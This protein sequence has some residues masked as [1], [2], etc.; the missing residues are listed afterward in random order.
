MP[1]LIQLRRAVLLALAAVTGVL[2][3]K[4]I[5]TFVDFRPAAITLGPGTTIYFSENP[6]LVTRV[7]EAIHRR[8]MRNKSILGRLVSAVRYNFD[9]GYRLEEEAEAKAGE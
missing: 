8:Q 6:T 2:V 3:S 9:Y 5:Q 7:H 1:A 4:G